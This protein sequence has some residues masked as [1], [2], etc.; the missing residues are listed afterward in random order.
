MSQN[1][2]RFLER[3][4][5]LSMQSIIAATNFTDQAENMGLRVTF[6]EQREGLAAWLG[7][8]GP[9]NSFQFFSPDTHVV[10][11]ARIKRPGDMLREVFSW[12]SD[13]V[14][15]PSTEP[16]LALLGRIAD[17]LGNEVAIG[18][19][20]PVLPVPNVKA[21]V[22]VLDPIGFHDGMVELITAMWEVH[23]PGDTSWGISYAVVDDYVVFGPGRP[24]LQSSIDAFVENQS[25]A[26]E[27][28]FLEALPAKS[29]TH[30]S[31]LLYA[32]ANQSMSE[33]LPFLE[34]IL[35]QYEVPFSVN[36]FTHRPVK[37]SKSAVYYAIAGDD[38]ID[39]YANGVKGEM[40]MTG[41]LP[42]VANWLGK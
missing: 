19:D 24:F 1:E 40:Q 23:T 42:A 33:A 18:L 38:S 36:I 26:Q 25:L 14:I 28:A 16:E 13:G 4:G 31:A 10:A 11:A 32:T 7:K 8:P 30:S 35:K 22:E 17:T 37:D 12:H 5:L 39:L 41:I 2:L 9:L 6:D 29:G 3:T 15:V 20:N 27:Y 34:G 21:T